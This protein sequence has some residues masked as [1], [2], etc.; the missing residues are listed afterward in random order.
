VIKVMAHFGCS[1][2]P[3]LAISLLKMFVRRYT[4]PYSLEKLYP[5]SSMDPNTF[6]IPIS[7]TKSTDQQFNGFIPLDKVQ[8]RFDSGGTRSAE[9]RFRVGECDWIPTSIRERFLQKY[10]H[11]I[12]K[13]GLFC[14][15]SDRTRVGSVNL[16]DCLDKIRF[17]I[18]ECAELEGGPAKSVQEEIEELRRKKEIETKIKLQVKVA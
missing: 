13:D 15:R 3:R 10:K 11:R 18:H 2:S 17:S 1:L 4:S 6:S 7:P 5:D 8:L 9:V 16:A 12:D 14:V